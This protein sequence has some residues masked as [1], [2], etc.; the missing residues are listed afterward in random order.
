MII[1][2]HAS[3]ALL[4]ALLQALLVGAGAW[5]REN[6]SHWEVLLLSSAKT[7]SA[8]KILCV[9]TGQAKKWQKFKIIIES[10]FSDFSDTRQKIL[11]RS[12]IHIILKGYVY[13]NV[14][15]AK[16]PN[17]LYS[18]NLLFALSNGSFQLDMVPSL[19]NE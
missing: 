16:C 6:G 3:D 4:G 5:K 11:S 19:A 14:S 18:L 9:P 1:Q 17:K 10:H 2:T 13:S 15:A 12:I 8:D 7:T